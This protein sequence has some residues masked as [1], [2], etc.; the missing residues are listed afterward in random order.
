MN[1]SSLTLYAG[2][3]W[4]WTEN[5]ANYL[6]PDFTLKLFLKLKN[7]PT[8]EFLSTQNGTGFDFNIEQIQTSIAPGNYSYQF[9][10]FDSQNVM[11]LV[12]AGTITILPNLST[13]DDSR[14]YWEQIA[15]EAK[16]AY[17]TLINQVADSITLSNGKTITFTNRKE[18]IKII[19]NAE[20]KAGIKSAKTRTFAK[21]INP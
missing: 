5:P 6:A 14:T 1:L 20:V 10:A 19:H 11:S 21:F 12:E 15:D 4:S 18:L 13:A 7:N 17:R 8:I 3:K 9:Q 2:S 16:Q